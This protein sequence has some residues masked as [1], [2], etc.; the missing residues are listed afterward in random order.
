MTW[1]NTTGGC[2]LTQSTIYDKRQTASAML[3]PEG[4]AAMNE[5]TARGCTVKEMIGGVA[6]MVLL[7]CPG[8]LVT[9]VSVRCR[10]VRQ[11][12]AARANVRLDHGQQRRPQPRNAPRQVRMGSRPHLHDGVIPSEDVERYAVTSAS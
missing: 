2:R 9:G 3:Y 1:L 6:A 12:R 10:L 8:L 5:T 7:N 11:F 4:S